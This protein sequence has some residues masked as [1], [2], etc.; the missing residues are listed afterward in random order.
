M[1]E[2]RVVVQILLIKYVEKKRSNKCVEDLC[3]EI[4]KC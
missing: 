1:E 3:D 4:G 2:A